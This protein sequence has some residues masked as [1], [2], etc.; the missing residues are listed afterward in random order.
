MNAAWYNTG[1]KPVPLISQGVKGGGVGKGQGSV[2]PVA[3]ASSP[4][5]PS[6][7]TFYFRSPFWSLAQGSLRVT[8]RL[9]M[10][11]SGRESGST[12]K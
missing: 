6:S 3:R 11:L 7:P 10:R 9:K 2:I 5:E 4:W 1:C 8:V 12:Q